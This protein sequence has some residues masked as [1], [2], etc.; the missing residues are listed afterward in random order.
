MQ[1]TTYLKLKALYIYV[2]DE[3]IKSLCLRYAHSH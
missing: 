2:H 3:A 1:Q